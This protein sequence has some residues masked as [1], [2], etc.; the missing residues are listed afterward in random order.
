M[1]TS[2]DV[3][4]LTFGASQLGTYVGARNGFVPYRR[5]LQWNKS[6]VFWK[7]KTK[8][9]QN[10]ESFI[11]HYKALVPKRYSYLDAKKIKNSFRDKL[12]QGGYG[13]VY[14]GKLPD[15]RIVAVKILNASKGNG[16]EF[17]NEV[18]SISRTSRV[19]IVAFLGFCL[20]SSKRALIC[21][22]MPNGSLEKFI[23]GENPLKNGGHLGLEKL[24]IQGLEYLHRGCKIRILHFDIK[25][26]NILLDEDFCLR[27]RAC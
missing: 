11:R 7:K 5:K 13:G 9:D 19:N 20:E 4:L 15:G 26:H 16:E 22:F 10:L 18:V 6:I 3:S 23:Y 2:S 27:L 24:L 12:G 25:P 1:G 8:N 21:K 17:I 14:K